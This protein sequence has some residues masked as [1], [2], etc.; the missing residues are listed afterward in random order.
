MNEDYELSLL[1]NTEKVCVRKISIYVTIR[2]KKRIVKSII[3][4]NFIFGKKLIFTFSSGV[5]KTQCG[6]PAT[7]YNG[8]FSI[9]LSRKTGEWCKLH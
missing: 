5:E 7:G 2:K 9:T 4:N 8:Y 1:S 3:R 6:I